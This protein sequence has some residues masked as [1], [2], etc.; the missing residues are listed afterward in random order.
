MVR[1]KTE[2]PPPV[3]KETTLAN[4]H[5]WLNIVRFGESGTVIQLQ[6][7]CE[8]SVLEII[9]NPENYFARAL[10]YIIHRERKPIRQTRVDLANIKAALR[11]VYFQGIRSDYRGTYWNYLWGVAKHDIGDIPDAI[12]YAVEGHHLI[13]LTKREMARRNNQLGLEA[14]V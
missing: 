10:D 6:D 3:T 8:Y 9:N 5:R 12:R 7:D 14:S 1:T 2:G 11:S 4:A 13:T